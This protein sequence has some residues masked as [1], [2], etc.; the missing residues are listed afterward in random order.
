MKTQRGAAALPIT[1][2]L[3]FAVLLAVAFANR[4]VLLQVRTSVHQLHSAQ[5]HEAAQAGLAWTLAQLNQVAPIG[6]DCQPSNEDGASTL[7]QRAQLG[8]LQASCVAE[9][10][11]WSCICPASGAT[12]PAPDAEAAS[13]QASLTP[14]PVQPERWQL[15]VTGRNR[16]SDRPIRLQMSL[17]RLPGLDTLPSAALAVRG[18]VSFSAEATL[19][20]TDPAS[21]GVT[22]H[23]GGA[24]EGPLLRVL[25]TPG[26]PSRASILRHDAALASLS[27]PGLH[28][29][30]FRMDAATWRDQPGVARVS[31]H[32]PCDEA[33]VA[34]ARQH[35]RIALDGGLRLATPL[36]LGTPA[37]PLLLVVD[38]PVD[39]AAAATLHG[40][41]YARHPQWTTSAG[42]TVRG[43]VIAEH[44]LRVDGPLH[45][46]HDAAVLQALQQRSGTYAPVSASWRDL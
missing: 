9:P 22:L 30:V 13:F 45:L 43:A 8:P 34:A 4:S 44:D 29:S 40:F 6:D 33:L 36:A 41:V 11:G 26:T 24:A 12:L 27:A 14:D 15:A 46:H 16:G 3:S 19:T 32:Q 2:V 37:R 17:G 21:G 1:L 5:A 20:H 23:S 31:C 7:H 28:A 38:G 25:S 35:T 18:S 39:V 42:L 10:L